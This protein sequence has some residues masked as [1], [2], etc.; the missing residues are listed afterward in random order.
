M[1]SAF[2]RIW[3]VTNRT[4]IAQSLANFGR[5]ATGYAAQGAASRNWRIRAGC[6]ATLGEIVRRD[7]GDQ[8][9]VDALLA[10][11]EAGDPSLAG[12]LVS[13]LAWCGAC[14]LAQGK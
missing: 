7:P 11:S 6:A 13:G 9:A 2:R 14:L 4:S 8:R 5:D 12:A 3:V 10:L 1:V